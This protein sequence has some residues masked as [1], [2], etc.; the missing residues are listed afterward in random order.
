M[1][2]NPGPMFIK[3]VLMLIAT[4]HEI[5]KYYTSK[6]TKIN[7][8]FLDLNYVLFY[9]SFFNVDNFGQFNNYEPDQVYAQL[10]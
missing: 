5:T 7:N 1:A 8:I 10:S 4:L 2:L 3:K 6:N 9:S